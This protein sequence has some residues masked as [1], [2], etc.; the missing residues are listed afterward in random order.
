MKVQMPRRATID[1]TISFVVI[2]K[3][4][5]QSLMM[6]DNI[7]PILISGKNERGKDGVNYLESTT[8]MRRRIS[9]GSVRSLH[10]SFRIKADYEGSLLP[11]IDQSQY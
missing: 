2:S 10:T 6:L 7:S 5:R 11:F 9:T 4:N 1:S 8:K 3:S